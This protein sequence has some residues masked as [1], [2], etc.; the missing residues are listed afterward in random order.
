M[1]RLAVI[2]ACS[3]AI[4]TVAP[5]VH[6]DYMLLLKNGR[7]ITVQSYRDEGT[8][9]KFYGFGGEIGIAK[10][11]IRSITKTAA[12]EKKLPDAPETD[13]AGSEAAVQ[14]PPRMEP[15]TPAPTERPPSPDEERAK[16]EQEYQQKLRSVTERLSDVRDRFAQS[17]RG[18]SSRDPALL[19]S[20]DEID[21]LND[22]AAAR[23]LDAQTN[24]VDPGV[25]KLQTSSPFSSLPPDTVD[26]RLSAPTAATAE[27][28]P[29]AYTERQK[30]LSDLRN[31]AI[32]LETE[33]ER[34]IDE[35]KQK[36]FATGLLFTE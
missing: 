4:W 27:S 15:G 36:N 8:V 11:Q 29:P 20:E 32:R 26:Q 28:L 12:M 34:L 10:D 13:G 23:R 17:T 6:A 31:E 22:D 2:A 9:I 24:P 1:K 19:T 18:S 7:R 16:E 3:A 30:E 25:L 21:R 35:M 14:P 33:R 5:T